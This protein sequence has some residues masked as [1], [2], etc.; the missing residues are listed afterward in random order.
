VSGVVAL[1]AKLAVIIAIAAAVI[2]VLRASDWLDPE[3]MG[4][5]EV[6]AKRGIDF[7]IATESAENQATIREELEGYIIVPDDATTLLF[8]NPP[9]FEAAYWMENRL[10]NSDLG[11]IIFLYGYGIVGSLLQYGFYGLILLYAIR[12]GRYS[13]P[14]AS[15]SIL[16]VF[17]ILLFHAKEVFVFTRIGLSMT[18]LFIAALL[19]TKRLERERALQTEAVT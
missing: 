10:V 12:Y 5:F 13:K 11:Y 3:Q 8:G 4:L 1:G 17:V 9:L 14:L 18:T 16:L 7:F 6:A 2:G 19:C 15:I